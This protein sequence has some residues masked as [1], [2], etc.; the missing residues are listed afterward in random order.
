VDPVVAKCARDKARAEA[1]GRSIGEASNA[2]SGAF[3]DN[4]KGKHCA[5]RRAALPLAC[6]E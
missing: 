4:P 1:N 3:R 5:G 6:V 2:V